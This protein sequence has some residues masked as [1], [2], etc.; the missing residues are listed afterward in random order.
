[1]GS[2]K[3]GEVIPKCEFQVGWTARERNKVGG[4]I[5]SNK[6]GEKKRGKTKQSH[7]SVARTQA[8]KAHDVGP[9][10]S[11]WTRT[12]QRSTLSSKPT[13]VAEGLKRKSSKQNELVEE[14]TVSV[15]KCRTDEEAVTG[16]LFIQ[17]LSAEAA[18]QSRR[19]Q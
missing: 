5:E 16:K 12:P 15:K 2:D 7:A 9:K 6:C 18:V 11:T 14:V 17:S 10:K 19:E 13:P 3:C 8:S 4:R 1:M